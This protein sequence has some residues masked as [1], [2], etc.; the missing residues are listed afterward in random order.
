M[1]LPISPF[2][3]IHFLKMYH[4]NKS[5]EQFLGFSP[6]AHVARP[7][8]HMVGILLHIYLIE[9]SNICITILGHHFF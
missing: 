2:S 1:A 9:L 7:I 6:V 3:C 8:Q 4:N 5:R